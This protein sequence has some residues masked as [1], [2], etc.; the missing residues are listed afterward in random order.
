MPIN[1]QF[2][3]Y[4][5]K[6]SVKETKWSSLLARTGALILYISI[7]IFDFGPE[8]L[9]GLSRNGPPVLFRRHFGSVSQKDIVVYLAYFNNSKTALKTWP[10]SRSGTQNDKNFN[11]IYKYA[12]ITKTKKELTTQV[13]P[14]KPLRNNPIKRLSKI[15]N[16]PH[17]ATV[18][19]SRKLGRENSL[20]ISGPE[21]IADSSQ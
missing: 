12:K 15:N 21:G 13:E 1:F 9:S 6:L 4:M 17:K 19:W 8:K 20:L 2:A 5:I 16:I 18:K 11:Y 14:I 3:S 10:Q 7:W